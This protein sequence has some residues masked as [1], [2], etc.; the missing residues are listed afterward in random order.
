MVIVIDVE[1]CTGCGACVD[2]CPTAAIRLI[3]GV[4]TVNRALCRECEVCV[5][6]CP[7]SAIVSVSEPQEEPSRLPQPVLE[8]SPRLPAEERSLKATRASKTGPWLGAA[9]VFVGREILPRIV[10]VLL[11]SWERGENLAPQEPHDPGQRLV[12][13]RYSAGKQ[14]RRRWRQGRA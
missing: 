5:D 7:Q 6:A 9:A 3:D 8:R 14:H 13:T 11:E 2:A 1:R 12:V 10:A 4:A